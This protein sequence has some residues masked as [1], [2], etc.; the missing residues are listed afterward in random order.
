[1]LFEL[2][3]WVNILRLIYW[4]YKICTFYILYLYIYYTNINWCENISFF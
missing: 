4:T 2:I 3:Y 1:M